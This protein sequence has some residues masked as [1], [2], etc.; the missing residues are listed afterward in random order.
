MTAALITLAV[1][2]AVSVLEGLWAWLL[3]A[4]V[5]EVAGQV[6]PSW[7]FVCGLLAVA[8]LVCRVLPLVGLSEERRRWSL[9]HDWLATVI[10]TW[11]V[12]GLVA[13]PTSV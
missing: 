6:Q 5:S 4:A 8:W 10:V 12:A 2:L 3:A 11:S 7:L 1:V 13:P 9:A